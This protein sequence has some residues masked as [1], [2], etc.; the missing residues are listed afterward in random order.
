MGHREEA[1]WILFGGIVL[2]FMLP[3]LDFSHVPRGDLALAAVVASAGV[4]II[5]W[6]FLRESRDRS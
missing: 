5:A 2:L 6:L 4:S 3:V 1:Q